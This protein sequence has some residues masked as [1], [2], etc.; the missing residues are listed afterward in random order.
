MNDTQITDRGL[1]WL[2]NLRQL[3]EIDLSGTCVTGKSLLHLSPTLEAIAL[4]RTGVTD[5]AIPELSRFTNLTRLSL[6]DTRVT[7][8]ICSKLTGLANLSYLDISWTNASECIRRGVFAISRAADVEV[9]T[10]V[11]HEDEAEIRQLIGRHG[12]GE[13][14]IRFTRVDN[15]CVRVCAATREGQLRDWGEEYTVRK[16]NGRWEVL[17]AKQVDFVTH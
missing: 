12:V 14:V 8:A 5:L 15:F 11:S 4:S 17:E 7:N 16:M 3:R 10:R 6:Y 1:H 9:G 2:A 13:E